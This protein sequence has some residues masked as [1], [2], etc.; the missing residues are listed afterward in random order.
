MSANFPANT[1]LAQQA[2]IVGNDSNTIAELG[3]TFNQN[4]CVV[5]SM[6]E[7]AY[8]FSQPPTPREYVYYI[9]DTLLPT[10][11]AF[12]DVDVHGIQ[13]AIVQN[14]LDKLY[15]AWYGN[16]LIYN[17]VAFIVVTKV[18]LLSNL[19]YEGTDPKTASDMFVATGI[20][21]HFTPFVPTELYHEF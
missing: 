21:F 6:F 12:N 17:R 11:I 3:R 1:D 2:F 16:Y 14:G 18:E 9:E 10:I 4:E 15:Q 7:Q 8:K 19:T 13:N 5:P 20:K